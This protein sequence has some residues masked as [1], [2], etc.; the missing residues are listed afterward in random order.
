MLISENIILLIKITYLQ[1][2]LIHSR[3]NRPICRSVA[4]A[5]YV[6]ETIAGYDPND[7]NATREASTYIPTGGYT[8]FLRIN[9]LAGKRLGIVRN[10][11]FSFLND[12]EVPL[13]FEQ[14]FKTLR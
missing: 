10:P 5:V 7:A 13:V 12:S 1:A 6:L 2:K 4:D 3:G 14:H 8:Q 11:F 9:G